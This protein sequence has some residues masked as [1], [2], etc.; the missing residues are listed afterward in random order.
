MHFEGEVD[1]KMKK[2]FFNRSFVDFRKNM[3]RRGFKLTLFSNV[4][5][6][7][8]R[9]FFQEQPSREIFKFILMHYELF[10]ELQSVCVVNLDAQTVGLKVKVGSM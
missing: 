10:S 3:F 9:D 5:R 8:K 6:L 2:I 1:A 7:R 4:A